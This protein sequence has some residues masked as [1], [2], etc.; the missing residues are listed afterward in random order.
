[1]KTI[2]L[3]GQPII[4]ISGDDL[5]RVIDATREDRMV[6]RET[7]AQ[8]L[9][10]SPQTIDSFREKG[11]IKKYYVNDPGAVKPLSRYKYSELMGIWDKNRVL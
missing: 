3:T 1:M 8:L 9:D 5:Q 10:V 2:Q 4:Q 11:L 6:S 7:A